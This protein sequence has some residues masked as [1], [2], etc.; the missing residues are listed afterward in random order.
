MQLIMV[1]CCHL[2]ERK[3]I[4]WVDVIPIGSMY[5]I[6]TYIYHK[7]QQ[8][9]G[10]Y[11]SPTDPM[12]ITTPCFPICKAS[13]ATWPL[14][15]NCWTFFSGT[16]WPCGH[17]VVM[18]NSHAWWRW[19]VQLSPGVE[20]CGKGLWRNASPVGLAEMADSWLP[21]SP[22]G[23]MSRATGTRRKNGVENNTRET[24]DLAIWMKWCQ[25]C[26]MSEKITVITWND[27]KIEV[28]PIWKS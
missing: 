9:I 11:T 17:V 27:T 22:G 18:P 21:I 4:V 10:K 5:G 6:F 15:L 28:I 26:L 7:N 25:W 12:G 2:P 14:G 1:I 3:C 19:S 20:S 23:I 8:N 24:T 13:E 16:N